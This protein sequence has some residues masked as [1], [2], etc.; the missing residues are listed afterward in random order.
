MYNNQKQTIMRKKMYSTIEEI[1]KDCEK[2]VKVYSQN[3]LYEVR[4]LNDM[5]IVWCERTSFSG[6]KID[7]YQPYEFYNYS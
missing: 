7:L 3:E 2:G 6:G 5:Y 1:I 4:K